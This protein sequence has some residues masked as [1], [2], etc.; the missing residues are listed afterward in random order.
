M[1]KLSS[2]LKKGEVK[3]QVDSLDDL[4]YLSGLIDPGDKVSGKTLRKLKIGESTERSMKVVRKPV[5]MEIEVQKIEFGKTSPVLRVS[6]KIIQGPEDAPKGSH[7]TFNV[8]ENTIITI[9]K[10][11]WLSYQLD[12]LKEATAAKQPKILICVMDREE[13]YF[14]KM[15]QYGYELISKLEGDVQ[16][17]VPGEKKKSDFYAQLI[18][19]LEAYDKRF[20]LD[21]IILASPAFF[22]DDL[23]KQLTN[24]ELRKKIILATCSS[25]GNN[26]IDEVLKREETRTALAEDRIA[27]EM[28]L[29]EQLLTEISKNNL[30][31]YGLKETKTA[32]EAGAADILLITDSL[33]RK[34]REEDAYDQLDYIMK[35]V[36]SA[37]GK[38]HIISSEHEAGKKLDGLGGIGAV[39]RYKMNY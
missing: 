8:E 38:V 20:K 11:K 17:K 33:I 31:T 2:N 7:H 6:G 36:D 21:K 19:T 13:A 32:A 35:T 25:V 3:A 16:K 9:T 30:A 37:K 18:K 26:G 22:K 4:W 39:L 15:R 12:R 23:M 5:F 10:P 29:V 24:E 34:K 1:K 14:A 28:R 27:K